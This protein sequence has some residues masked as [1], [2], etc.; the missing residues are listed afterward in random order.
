MSQALKLSGVAILGFALALVLLAL[1]PKPHDRAELLQRS[2]AR[3][4][5]R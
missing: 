2:A 4:Q 5:A 3:G 1:G